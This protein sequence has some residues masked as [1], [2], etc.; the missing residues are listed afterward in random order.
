MWELFTKISHGRL[1]VRRFSLLVTTLLVTFLGISSLL[2]PVAHAADD[3]VTRKGNDVSYKGNTYTPVTGTALP[4]DVVESAPDTSGYRYVDADAKKAYFILTSGEPGAATSGYYVV[5]TYTPPSNYSDPSPPA[6]VTIGA[7]DGSTTDTADEPSACDGA[8]LG[9]IGWIVCPTVNFIAKGMDKIYGIV[10]SFLEVKTMTGDTDSSIYKLWAV[11]RDI[12]NVAFVIAFIII[13]YSQMTGLGINNYGLKKMLPRLV[14]AA[15]LVNIS[16]WICAVAVDASNVLGYSIHSIFTG[17]MDKFSVGGNYT[18]SIPT[19]QQVA[20]ISLSGTAVVAGGLFVLAN[21]VGGTVFLL[22]PFLLGVVTAALIALIVLAARQALITILIIVAPLAFVAYVLPNTEKYF[23]KWREAMMTMLLLFPIFSILFSGAQVAGMAIVQSAGGNLFTIILG[24]AVQVAPIVITPMLVKFSGSLIGKVAGMVNNPNKG[25]IDR[26]RKWADGKKNE[27]KNK[28]LAGQNKYFR[29]NPMHRATKALDSRRRRIDGTRKVYESMAENR[30]AD[31]DHGRNVEA[32]NRSANNEKQRV[33]NVFANSAQGRQLEVQSRHLNTDKQE[34]DNSVTRSNAGQHATYRQHIADADKTRVSNEFEETT[35]GD[36]AEHAKRLVEAEK[37]KID[38]THQAEWDEKLRTDAN[39]NHL[40][41]G[42]KAS[43]I[44]AA[45]EK[46]KLEKMHS[47]LA[48]VGNVDNS[49]SQEQRDKKERYLREHV[50]NLRGGNQAVNDGILQ[51]A[52]NIQDNQI[53]SN[54]TNT[55][56]QNADHDLN[57]TI[58]ST[59]L[60]NN[61]KVEGQDIRKYAAGL[62]REDTVLAH[63]VATER[64]EFGEQVSYQKQLA[65]HFKLSAADT[66]KL[67]KGLTSVKVKDEAGNQHTFDVNSEYVRDMAAEQIFTVGS[68]DDIMAVINT[69]GKGQINHAYRRTIMNAAIQS[70]FA[71]KN[72]AIADK[73]LDII[74]NGEFDGEPSWQYHALREVLEGRINASSLATAHAN[75]L[76]KLFVDVK[77]DPLGKAQ[78]QKLV[79]DSWAGELKKLQLTNPNATEQDAR[80]EVI[81]KFEK[82]RESLREMAATVVNSPTVSQGTSDESANILK[83][84]GQ[85]YLRPNKN[86]QGGQNQRQGASQ[87]SQTTGG[88]PTNQGSQNSN[89]GGQNR[90]NRGSRPNQSNPNNG[91]NN[92]PGGGQ[93]N[94]PRPGPNPNTN[95]GTP[96]TP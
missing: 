73:T 82:K 44:K 43:E 18:G 22:I 40:E 78:F 25:L 5:Y 67:T 29:R 85:Q 16:F 96:P 45:V 47:E 68:H 33:D 90:R 79:D 94:P 58:N 24:M 28:V 81:T 93:N 62:G 75:S 46:A 1:S 21:T 77:S 7:A 36:K 9:G 59:L 86:N 63:S 89:S 48:A 80:A 56:K 76:G 64:K 49:S 91:T 8:T 30:F 13:V 42:V 19:W 17:I 54:V 23:N 31:T 53:V 3:A 57:S 34:I 65:D 95:P 6:S 38:N 84:F 87:G 32:L 15:G 51:I 83:Q 2:A 14:I 20:A 35:L 4:S 37:R 60:H 70:G 27:Q 41:L 66:G 72:P 50:Q 74:N 61:V 92:N 39:L 26:S 52:R 12:A 11:I 10:A 69:T 55:A 71:K 88:N